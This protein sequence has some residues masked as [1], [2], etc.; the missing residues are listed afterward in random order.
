MRI[1]DLVFPEAKHRPSET[2][3]LSVHA[4]VAPPIGFD[5]ENPKAPITFESGL[6]SRSPP[7]SMPEIAVAENRD[8]RRNQGKVGLSRNTILF[9]IAQAGLPERATEIAFDFRAGG[10][11][12]R[13][14]AKGVFRPFR[15]EE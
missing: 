3:Q 6:D 10:A 15:H 5:F 9:A 12:A 7:V 13:H 2:A 11:D 4:P 1:A 14:F 8:A